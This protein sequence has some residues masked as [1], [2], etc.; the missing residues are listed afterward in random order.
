MISMERGMRYALAFSIR[1]LVNRDK[2]IHL[3]TVA[4]YNFVTSQLNER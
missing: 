1:D 3:D 2:T 4:A